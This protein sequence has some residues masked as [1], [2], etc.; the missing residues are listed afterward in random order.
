MPETVSG[1]V[2][3]IVA[4]GSFDATNT[5]VLAWLNRRHKE[6]VCRARGYR[7]ALSLGNTV[8]AQQEYTVPAG[9][10]ELYDVSVGGLPYGKGRRSDIVENAQG[11]LWLSGPGGEVIESASSS[12]V[13][14]LALVPVPSSGGDAIAAFAA[15][16]PPDLLI[17]NSV[18]LVVD[19]EF[20][21][22]LLAG[23][24]AT[25]LNRPNEGRSDLAAAQQGIFEDYV[26][27]YSRRVARRL[28]GPGPS[29]IRFRMP[30]GTTVA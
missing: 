19:D 26:S 15:V 5:E 10:V 6:M 27:R 9:V 20:V 30:G 3:E 7:K 8:A 25:A 28:R 29:R 24:F 14:T 16:A 11:W 13:T 23:V 4:Q 17:D 1:L 18:P 22:G 2:G 12:A 21:E